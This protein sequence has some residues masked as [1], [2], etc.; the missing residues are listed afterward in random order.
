MGSL[1]PMVPTARQSSWCRICRNRYHGDV[2]EMSQIIAGDPEI[3]FR[4]SQAISEHIWKDLL[5]YPKTISLDIRMNWYPQ[6]SSEILG[7][8]RISFWG[9]LPG[10]CISARWLQA[11]VRECRRATAR[12]HAAG[13]R[14]R[15]RTFP[16]Q[17]CYMIVDN[18]ALDRAMSQGTTS[19]LFCL[20]DLP[21]CLL[22]N[23]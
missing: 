17:A 11:S 4:I 13:V 3:Y 9:E 16:G 6:I 14:A 22:S 7:Y 8:T 23:I 5:V 1:E 20:A 12:M 2:I 21:P 18:M 15:P 10:A 19:E